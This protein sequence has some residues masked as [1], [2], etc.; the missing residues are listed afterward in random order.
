MSQ[1]ATVSLNGE[2]LGPKTMRFVEGRTAFKLTSFG[3]EKGMAD[4]GCHA[5]KLVNHTDIDALL[6][7][8]IGRH[9]V[10]LR[11]LVADG[12]QKEGGQ[13]KS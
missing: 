11:C 2:S 4:F 13:K 7:A 9:E 10:V 3:D 8:N 1:T 6:W 5:Q 12:R